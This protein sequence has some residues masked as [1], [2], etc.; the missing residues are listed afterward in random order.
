MGNRRRMMG[1][2]DRPV[3]NGVYIEA[4]NGKLFTYNK[5]TGNLTPNSVVVIQNEVR[6]R[7]ALTQSSDTLK[8]HS[9]YSGALENYMT[10]IRDTEKAK[11]DMKSAENTANIMKVQSS[12]NYAAGYCKNFTFPDG[13]TKGLLPAL[14]WLWT[15]YDNK[16]AVD[17]CLAACRA[18]AM[19]TSYYHW[20]STYWGIGVES[21]GSNYYPHVWILN[22][23]DGYVYRH[24]IADW[25]WVRPFAEYV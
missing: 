25:Y 12:I 24:G 21:Q 1:L 2:K 18:K 23:P 13:K 3:M 11:L 7:I 8:I 20:S 15:A 16:A 5:W 22:W 19:G 9:S 6:F 14:G 17:A 4:T 10:A